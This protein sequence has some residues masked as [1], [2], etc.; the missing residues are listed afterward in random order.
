MNSI[1][2]PL[3][4]YACFMFAPFPL[5]FFPIQYSFDIIHKNLAYT[6]P[7]PHYGKIV[8][9]FCF[10]FWFR[11]LIDESLC[12]Q[13]Y[14]YNCKKFFLFYVLYTLGVIVHQFYSFLKRTNAHA[15]LHSHIRLCGLSIRSETNAERD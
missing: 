2:I 8:T 3:A 13:F 1:R 6:Q 11:S 4:N 12:K 9:F 15:H 7:R 14:V 10:L 5:I